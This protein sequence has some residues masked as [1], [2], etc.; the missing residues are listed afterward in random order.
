MTGLGQVSFLGLL[1]HIRCCVGF[2]F[3]LN[4]FI[5]QSKTLEKTSAERPGVLVYQKIAY[6]F[7][8]PIPDTPLCWC[9]LLLCVPGGWIT[10]CP[11]FVQSLSVYLVGKL[12]SPDT[13]CGKYFY[14]RTLN[15]NELL[16]IDQTRLC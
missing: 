14:Y 11:L 2:S 4:P 5:E 13:F 12:T 10:R 6:N 3:K 16:I 7:P 1:G 8:R 9:L 15:T